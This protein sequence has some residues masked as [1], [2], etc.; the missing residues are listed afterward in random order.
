MFFM[1]P[2][3]ISVKVYA[4][5]DAFFQPLPSFLWFMSFSLYSRFHQMSKKQ[6]GCFRSNPTQNLTMHPWRCFS[7]LIAYSPFFVSCLCLLKFNLDH[8][9]EFFRVQSYSMTIAHNQMSWL[10]PI[11]KATEKMIASFL[12]EIFSWKTLFFVFHKKSSD[13]TISIFFRKTFLFKMFIRKRRNV[14]F[15]VRI[16]SM[17]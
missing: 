2:F 3:N 13:W 1:M 5:N 6:K 17:V 12:T 15:M 10:S 8:T 4:T 16:I 9:L 14:D 7:N 11:K